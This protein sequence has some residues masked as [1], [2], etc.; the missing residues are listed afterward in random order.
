[1]GELKNRVVEGAVWQMAQRVFG[2]VA[3][4]LVTLVLSRVL[5]PSDY[6]TVALLSIFLAVSGTLVDCGLGM[7]LVHCVSYLHLPQVKRANS[8]EAWTTC[9]ACEDV[10]AG[11]D[12]VARFM[13]H[14]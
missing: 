11:K 3:G 10:A 1:M 13:P 4:F 5:T 12:V 7:A 14:G 8:M 2:Q 9:F 6:G